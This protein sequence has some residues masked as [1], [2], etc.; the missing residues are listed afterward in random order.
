M[1]RNKTGQKSTNQPIKPIQVVTNTH[2]LLRRGYKKL[3][4]RAI[5]STPS[6]TTA[7]WGPSRFQEGGTVTEKV[8]VQGPKRWY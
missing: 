2:P 5:S 3:W 6:K 7:G 4:Q 1:T 8:H